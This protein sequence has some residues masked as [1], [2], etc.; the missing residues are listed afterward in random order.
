MEKK[1]WIVFVPALPR[2][3][4]GVLEERLGIFGAAAVHFS[5]RFFFG[6]S[7]KGLSLAGIG[8]G[9]AT[10]TAAML[11]TVRQRMHLNPI[12]FVSWKGTRADI[13]AVPT[14]RL[15][16][17]AQCQ[18]ALIAVHS[19]CQYFFC[20]TSGMQ[21]FHFFDSIETYVDCVPD[22]NSNN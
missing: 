17:G 1:G 9:I 6:R 12:F 7:A 2:L 22:Y 13:A 4:S 14:E 18:Y 11:E 16:H 19:L 8:R 21:G 10:A 15:V 5:L 3:C 20:V